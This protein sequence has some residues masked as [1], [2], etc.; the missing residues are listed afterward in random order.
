M[1]KPSLQQIHNAFSMIYLY[2]LVL[3]EFCMTESP[4][5]VWNE[6]QF[7]YAPKQVSLIDR[8]IKGLLV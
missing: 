8:E 6:M 1:Y 5:F 4:S 2:I 7:G 3:A